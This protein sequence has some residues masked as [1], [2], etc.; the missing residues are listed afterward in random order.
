MDLENINKDLMIGIVL[1]LAILVIIWIS[2]YEGY[3]NGYDQRQ[4]EAEDSIEYFVEQF[5]EIP[6]N[7]GFMMGFNITFREWAYQHPEDI[8]ALDVNSFS[9]EFLETFRGTIDEH[10][11]D[12]VMCWLAKTGA[13]TV[14]EGDYSW[15]ESG[16]KCKPYYDEITE[17]RSLQNTG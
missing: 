15:E 12:S 17:F 16:E 13:F 2:Y 14:L 5:E 9:P 10:G 8:N 6:F 1:G 3:E 11:K 7:Q 4:L